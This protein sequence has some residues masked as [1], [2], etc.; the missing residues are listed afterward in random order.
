MEKGYVYIL[1]SDTDQK[2]YTG[3]TNN[4]ARRL[5]SH[6][7]GEV[8]ATKHRRPLRL[9]YTEEFETLSEARKREHYLK[10]RQ[11]R[12]ELKII[13]NKLKL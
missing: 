8:T 9:V 10:T 6:N 1:L 5:D 2:S 11:G 7:K 13:F 4:L 3:S 12:K